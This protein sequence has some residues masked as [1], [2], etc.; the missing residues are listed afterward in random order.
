MGKNSKLKAAFKSEIFTVSFAPIWVIFRN[1]VTY[2][3]PSREFTV[4]FSFIVYVAF[5]EFTLIIF[6]HIWRYWLCHCVYYKKLE[7]HILNSNR[8]T[9]LKLLYENHYRSRFANANQD[10]L[11]NSENYCEYQEELLMYQLD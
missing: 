6:Y 9:K 11:P 7:N 2:V 10:L 4:T 3:K 8:T 5:A 1:S